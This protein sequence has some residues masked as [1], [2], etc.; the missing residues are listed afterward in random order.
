MSKQRGALIN[1]AGGGSQKTEESN[2]VIRKAAEAA[3]T[4]S[5]SQARGDPEPS[6]GRVGGV[7]KAAWNPTSPTLMARRQQGGDQRTLFSLDSRKLALSTVTVSGISEDETHQSC[8]TPRLYHV[9][10]GFFPV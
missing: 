1:D 4:D 8:R 7:F 5:S 3:E 6:M 10:M 2:A 9:M